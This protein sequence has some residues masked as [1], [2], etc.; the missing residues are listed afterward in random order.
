MLVHCAV[1]ACMQKRRT[2]VYASKNTNAKNIATSHVQTFG[3]LA[4]CSAMEENSSS[5]ESHSELDINSES[6]SSDSEESNGSM[7]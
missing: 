1:D 6:S 7:E 4:Q 2:T 5:D 3:E